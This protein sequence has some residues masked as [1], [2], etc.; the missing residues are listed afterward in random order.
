M[1]LHFIQRSSHLLE[2]YG[3]VSLVTKIQF[4]E[5]HAQNPIMNRANHVSLLSS[6]KTYVNASNDTAISSMQ[7]NN[8]G[9]IFLV[10][11]SDFQCLAKR[12]DDY[13][14]S[15]E[16]VI[17]RTR[18]VLKASK[19]AIYALHKNDVDAAKQRIDTAKEVIDTLQAVFQV[20]FRI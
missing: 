11:E 7:K 19:Q 17:K 9:T 1:S 13:D 6:F 5:R 14:R 2:K 15:R 16:E 4:I 18:D 10:D 12:H 8:T 3:S 20:R